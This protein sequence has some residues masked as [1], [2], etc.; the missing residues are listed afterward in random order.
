MTAAL[1]LFGRFGF[2]DATAGQITARDPKM[3]DQW[4]VNPPGI[5]LKRIRVKDLVLVKDQQGEIYAARPDVV[6]IASASPCT[7]RPGRHNGV[8]SIP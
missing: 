4:W 6:A 7:V 1:R 2:D 3:V 5:S 8:S